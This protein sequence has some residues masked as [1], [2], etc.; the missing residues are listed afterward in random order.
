MTF[1][2]NLGIDSEGHAAN[3]VE[4]EQIVHYNGSRASFVQ[5]SGRGREAARQ[6]SSASIGLSALVLK[7]PLA[8][9]LLKVIL[10]SDMWGTFPQNKA[11]P[12][13]G[14]HLPTFPA[15]ELIKSL[16]RGEEGRSKG[17]GGGATSPLHPLHFFKAVMMAQKVAGE[18]V[19][20]PAS[21]GAVCPLLPPYGAVG[22]LFSRTVVAQRICKFMNILIRGPIKHFLVLPSCPTT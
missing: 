12:S 6:P 18:G 14:A 10:L 11:T 13:P 19:T 21:L 5:A 15:R 7:F 17:Y 1:F 20:H 16:R 22:H 9:L 8:P 3:F 4:T 2:F